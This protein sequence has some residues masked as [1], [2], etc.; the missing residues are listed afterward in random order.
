M[1]HLKK[2]ERMGEGQGH[3]RRQRQYTAA[4]ELNSRI[5]KTER[6]QNVNKGQTKLGPFILSASFMLQGSVHLG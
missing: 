2:R 1:G 5:R 4:L 3:E 6:A